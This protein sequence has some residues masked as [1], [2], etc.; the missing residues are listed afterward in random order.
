M[1]RVRPSLTRRRCG[2]IPLAQ[3][4]AS[5]QCRI[6]PSLCKCLSLAASAAYAAP[7]LFSRRSRAIKL[8]CN[9][10]AQ[11]AIRNGRLCEQTNKQQRRQI[12][13]SRCRS[14]S[15]DYADLC[16]TGFRSTPGDGAPPAA[17][18][19]TAHS[20][21]AVGCTSHPVYWLCSSFNPGGNPPRSSGE[22][23]FVL[24]NHAPCLSGTSWNTLPLLTVT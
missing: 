20:T 1:T 3:S 22:W 4:S 6:R 5:Q 8:R 18:M 11:N 9:G 14:W 23:D 17:A 7:S 13:S 21:R 19:E 15:I 2:R 16:S 10:T 12:D 24:R